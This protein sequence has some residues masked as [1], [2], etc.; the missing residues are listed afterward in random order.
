MIAVIASAPVWLSYASPTVASIAFVLAAMTYRRAGPK[1]K[2][3][4][5]MPAGLRLK[6]DDIPLTVTLNSTGLA[7][8][9]VVR[10]NILLTTGG[11]PMVV[12][13]MDRQAVS[14]GPE[15]KYVLEAGHEEQW[16]IS[17]RCLLEKWKASV[18][19]PISTASIS[20]SN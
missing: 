2:V 1:V 10:L 8:V 9:Q 3:H 12:M 6:E 18:H 7:D 15:L 11:A 16:V 5:S 4:N 20:V 13:R 14:E 19:Y 17:L